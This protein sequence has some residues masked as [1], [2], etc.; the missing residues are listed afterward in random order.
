MA[1]Y[2]KILLNSM[3]YFFFYN[4]LILISICLIRSGK[5]KFGFPG[6]LHAYDS[7][8][9]LTRQ[10][11]HVDSLKF[12]KIDKTIQVKAPNKGKRATTVTKREKFT[13]KSAC[14]RRMVDGSK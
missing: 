11:V 13:L 6:L 14:C 4:L 7:P 12:S 1:M 2:D 10:C 9:I 8:I 3:K 5:R